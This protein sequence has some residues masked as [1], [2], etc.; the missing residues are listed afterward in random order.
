LVEQ[1]IEALNGGEKGCDRWEAIQC[2]CGDYCVLRSLSAN[3][4]QLLSQWQS[5]CGAQLGQEIDLLIIDT[6]YTWIHVQMQSIFQKNAQ[7]F[8]STEILD[9]VVLHRFLGMPIFIAVMYGMFVFAISIVGGLQ[10]S[11]GLLTEWIAVD[12]NALL[13]QQFGLPAGFIHLLAEGVGRGINTTL[14][15][16]PVLVG[17]YL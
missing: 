5:A 1:A 8:S 17:S 13:L 10:D 6:L 16:L 9:S 4:Q 12:G 7:A 11:V 15:F 2:L 3:Q 14:T